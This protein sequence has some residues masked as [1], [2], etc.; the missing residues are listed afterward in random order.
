MGDTGIVLLSHWLRPT[1]HK[2][3]RLADLI[4]ANVDHPAH[5]LMW[6]APGTLL[7]SQFLHRWTG[8]RRWADLYR[9]SARKLWSELVWSPQHR[10]SYWVQQ[11]YGDESAYL[12]AVHGFVGTAAV[13][14]QG[15][16]LLE[17]REWDAWRQ[18]IVDTVRNSAVREDHQAN[19]PPYLEPSKPAPTPRKMLMQFCHGAPGFVI[20]LADLPSAELD[21]D[22]LAAGEAI[23]SAGPLLKGSNLCHGTGGNGY[24]FL[25]LYQRTGDTRWLSRARAFAMHGIAQTEAQAREYGQMRYSLW[26]GD[27]GFAVYLRDCIRGAGAFPTLDTFFVAAD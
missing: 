16:R 20:C 1:A 25:K 5:E 15:R 4:A 13:I 27:L 8:E 6:G 11:L 21:D 14:I 17:A 23:W 2:A 12:G 7:A 22:L 3:A 19:W 26:T 10:C 9:A 24:A 18:C